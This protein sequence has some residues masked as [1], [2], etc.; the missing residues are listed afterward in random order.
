MNKKKIVIII[1]L[2]LI[3]SLVINK[4][5][6]NLRF[7]LGLTDYYKYNKPLTAKERS[8]VDEKAFLAGLYDYPPLTY[9]NQFNN[10]NVGIVVDYLSQLA[11]E[12]SS[13]IHI[14]VGTRD[15]LAD[16]LNNDETDIIMREYYN[17]EAV[18]DDLLITQP[19]CVVKT[20]ILV[21]KN[22]NIE[23]PQDLKDKSLVTLARDNENGRIDAVVNNLNNVNLIEVDN[24]YQCFALI[25][26]NVAVGFIGGDME[27]A[28]FLKVT[29][30]GAY[31]KFLKLTY[32]EKRICLAVKK[33]NK[34]M[35]DILNKGILQLKKKNLIAQT[36]YKWLGDFDTGVDLGTIES[37]YRVLIVIMFIIGGFSVWNY[38][39]TQRVNTRT[40][41]LFESKE[42]LRLIIDTMRNGIMVIEDDTTILECNDSIAEMTGV[43]KGKLIGANYKDL[44][45]LAPFTNPDNMFKVFNIGARYYYISRQKVAGNKSMVIVE[46]YTEK[47][48]K[49]K[50]ER[51]ESKMIAVGQ[52]SAGLAHEARN[53]LGLIK[54]YIYLIEKHTVHS[55][56]CR[57]AVSVINDSINRINY[58]VENL[59]RFSKLSSD[60]LKWTDAEDF[61]NSIIEE[62]KENAEKYDIIIYS[63][64]KGRYREPILINKEVLRMVLVN[65]IKNAVDSFDDKKCEEK[66][67][68]VNINV[69]ENHIDIEVIDNGCG[70]EKEALENIFDPFYS[71]KETGVGLGLYIINTEI[72]N[73][74][75][76]ISVKSEFGKGTEFKIT[77]PVVER[78]NGEKDRV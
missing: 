49:E 41:E 73:N 31:F 32:N 56:V 65:L 16:G 70:I 71:T 24:I 7:D 35:L 74:G 61:V 40:R 1:L 29:N 60:E 47:Y 75:G 12:L 42:E 17:G 68:H 39:I 10:Y 66:N 11:I 51:I 67:I 43:P 20:K 44:P 23:N 50:R 63:S 14:K 72:R 8:I 62:E 77:L 69:E 53:P 37:T 18:S 25:N 13:N 55:E 21:K 58:L 45:Q 30:R 64:F 76:T 4:F 22:L 26:N 28:H 19:L 38:I 6:K 57:H 36:Q 2:L 5:D 34:E 9:T 48:L 15:N 3:V 59:L 46:D 78:K 54:S 33:D 52:L 27:A